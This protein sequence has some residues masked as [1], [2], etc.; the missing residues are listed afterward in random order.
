MPSRD[1]A[2]STWHL[3]MG[4]VVAAAAHALLGQQGQCLGPAR[5]LRGGGPCT[6][7]TAGGSA[8]GLLVCVL[9]VAMAHA[10]L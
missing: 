3:F 10:C 6:P 8:S 5:G 4:L 1:S 7:R 9:A 2:G